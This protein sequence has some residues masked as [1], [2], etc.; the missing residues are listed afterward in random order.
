MKFLY[1][2]NSN[3]YY[4]Y[5]RCILM[6]ILSFVK[7]IHH[8]NTRGEIGKIKLT[9][10]L[11]DSLFRKCLPFFF[12]IIFF[13]FNWHHTLRY[14]LLRNIFF[15]FVTIIYHFLC[16]YFFIFVFFFSLRILSLEKNNLSKYRSK[17]ISCRTNSNRE[18]RM[19]FWLRINVRNEW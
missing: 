7:K 1:N 3:Y 14:L 4:V 8:I 10:M 9:L 2:S 13:I 17:L 16:N 15:R 19:S 11:H 5:I 18:N 12:Q 6:F